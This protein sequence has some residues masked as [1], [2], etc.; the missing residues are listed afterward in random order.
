[1]L[2]PELGIASSLVVGRRYIRCWLVL[3]KALAKT[4]GFTRRGVAVGKLTGVVVVTL[5]TVCGPAILGRSLV[6]IRLILRETFS[7]IE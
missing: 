5:L 6:E 2:S 7:N 3:A 4:R 1:M